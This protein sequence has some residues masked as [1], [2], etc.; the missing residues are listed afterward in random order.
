GTAC[1]VYSAG[2]HGA[3]ADFSIFQGDTALARQPTPD[4]L[5][6]DIQVARDNVRLAQESGVL[7][8]VA[9]DNKLAPSYLLSR[10][11]V[12][13]DVGSTFRVKVQDPSAQRA[14]RL[15]NGS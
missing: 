2:S 15:A 6:A 13:P 12:A 14:T 9:L 5:S 8:K 3:Y 10:T 11:S 1:A 4:L 7:V